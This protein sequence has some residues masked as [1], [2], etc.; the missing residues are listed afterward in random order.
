VID[1]KKIMKANGTTAVLKKH[2]PKMPALVSECGSDVCDRE[3]WVEF[4]VVQDEQ[5]W[6]LVLHGGPTG[7]ESVDLVKLLQ[8][9]EVGAKWV[10]C[11]G[12]HKYRRM[13]IR[14]DNI[15]HSV[16]SYNVNYEFEV[17]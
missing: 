6:W 13:E 11:A 15:R 16:K 3:V 4:E 2:L 17:L 5:G 12:S 1:F 14:V 7:Y 10:A 8:N 9:Q